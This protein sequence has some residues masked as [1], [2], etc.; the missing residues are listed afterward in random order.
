[1]APLVPMLVASRTI[2]R[3][4]GRGAASIEEQRRAEL[5]VVPVL[6]DVLRG[7]LALERRM[8]GL[9]RP[10]FGTSLVAVAARR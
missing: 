8:L 2:G 1:M 10:P 3:L 7:V 5:G 6:N 4:R 9:V